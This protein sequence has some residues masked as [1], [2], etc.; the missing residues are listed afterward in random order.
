MIHTSSPEEG[1][2]SL[3]LDDLQCAIKRA[4]VLDSLARCHHHASPDR[5]NGVGYKTGADCHN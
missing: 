4:L 1:N 3:V 5:V 2:D